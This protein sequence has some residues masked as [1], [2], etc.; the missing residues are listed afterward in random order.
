M[1]S[2]FQVDGEVVLIN[3]FEVPAGAIDKTI[4]MWKKSRDFLQKQPGYISTALHRSV[5]P[6]ATFQ[7]VN[8]ARWQS[9]ESFQAATA[10]MRADAAIEP[11]EGLRFT[12]G[13]Y[14]IILTD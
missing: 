8:I 13:L 14:Q 5:G 10:S 9:V 7:L 11:V 4:G 1:N 6:D 3:V 12:P 2:A